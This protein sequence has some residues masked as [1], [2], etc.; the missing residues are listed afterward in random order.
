MSSGGS[1]SEDRKKL[2]AIRSDSSGRVDAEPDEYTKLG[3]SELHR[4]SM[5][6]KHASLTAAQR[7]DFSFRVNT[8]RSHRRISLLEDDCKGKESRITN[9]HN[10]LHEVMAIAE[11]LQEKDGWRTWLKTQSR[12]GAGW[13]SDGNVLQVGPF[14]QGC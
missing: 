3:E 8:A 9:L 12:R 14:R 2:D 6:A 10:R 5:E 11:R 7:A 1:G 4:A 13:C